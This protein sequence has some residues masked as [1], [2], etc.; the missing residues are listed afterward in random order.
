MPPADGNKMNAKAV[1]VALV[2]TALLVFAFPYILASFSMAPNGTETLF[3]VIALWAICWVT[4]R[5]L[6]K[7]RQ[8]SR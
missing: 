5:R 1:L 6:E 7:R 8:P 2:G 3:L 4:S